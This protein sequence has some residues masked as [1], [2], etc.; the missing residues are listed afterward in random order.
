VR[1]KRAGWN[2][3]QLKRMKKLVE[4]SGLSWSVIGQRFRCGAS[5]VADLAKKH[6]WKKK[7]AGAPTS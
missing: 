3:D 7:I 5:T 2:D 1:N 4:E 6:G